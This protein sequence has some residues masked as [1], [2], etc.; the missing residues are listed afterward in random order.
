M[1]SI[2]QKQDLNIPKQPE[3]A[4]FR[5][6]GY[7]AK[8]NRSSWMSGIQFSGIDIVRIDSLRVLIDEKHHKK[9]NLL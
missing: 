6:L 5:L 1:L 2:K 3:D 8:K 9:I 7:K 4:G